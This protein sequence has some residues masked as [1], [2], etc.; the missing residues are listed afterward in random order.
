MIIASPK[1]TVIFKFQKQ[2][3]QTLKTMGKALQIVQ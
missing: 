3:E 2:R 1:K